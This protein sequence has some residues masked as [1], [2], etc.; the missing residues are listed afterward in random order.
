MKPIIIYNCSNYVHKTT[1]LLSLKSDNRN[2][3]GSNYL[4]AEENLGNKLQCNNK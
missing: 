1:L 2:L 4:A 3:K